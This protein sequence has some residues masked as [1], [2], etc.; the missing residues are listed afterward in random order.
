MG[1][2]IQT[3]T[4]H[5]KAEQ[6]A[7]KFNGNIVDELTAGMTMMD[8]DKAVIVVVDNGPF[9]A[10]AFAYNNSE[11][12]EFTSIADCRPRKFVIIDRQIAKEQTGYR[13]D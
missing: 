3:D 7:K 10:A 1:Y 13:G 2:Y 4:N 8:R 9:E 6:I 11:F 5:G 12:M